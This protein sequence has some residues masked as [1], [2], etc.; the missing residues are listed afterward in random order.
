[1]HLNYLIRHKR[2]LGPGR[3]LEVTPIAALK[4]R[5]LIADGRL[6]PAEQWVRER[7]NYSD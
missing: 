7:V 6:V 5:I 1:M 3:M 2:H 4:S